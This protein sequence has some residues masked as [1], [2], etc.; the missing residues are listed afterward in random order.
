MGKQQ[1]EQITRAY[2]QLH[3]ESPGKMSGGKFSAAFRRFA[4]ALR[5]N[6]TRLP[7]PSDPYGNSESNSRRP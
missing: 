1:S 2:I 5:R 3:R 6:D 4:Q 7:V